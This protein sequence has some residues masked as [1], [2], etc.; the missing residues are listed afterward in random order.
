M[1]RAETVEILL[2][3]MKQKDDSILEK[4][5]ISTDILVCNQAMVGF[6]YHEYE[7]NNYRVRWFDFAERGVGLNRNNA[8]MRADADICILSD[9]DVIYYDDYKEI[10]LEAFNNNPSADV[11]VFNIDSDEIKRYKIAKRKKINCLTCGKFGAVRIAFRKNSILKYDISFNLLFGGG[12]KFSAGEDTAFLLSCIKH[13]LNIV[14][15]PDKI[16]RLD[17]NSES[18]WFTGYHE[19]FFYDTGFTYRHHYGKRAFLFAIILIIKHR[20]TFL[21][22]ISFSSALVEIKNGIRD[23]DLY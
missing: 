7:K 19:K 1:K 9:D 14:A 20:K 22:D 8:L 2:A 16:L 4:M 13:K 5:N 10:V 18:S 15:V 23:F 21:K 12:A 6:N 3:T 11:I 17:M